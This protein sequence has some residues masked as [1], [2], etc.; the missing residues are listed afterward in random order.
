MFFRLTGSFL[1]YV[2]VSKVKIATLG[3]LKKKCYVKIN[4]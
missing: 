1:S 2:T 4:K 3:L